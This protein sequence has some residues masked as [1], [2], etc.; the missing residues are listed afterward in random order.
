M[1]AS[2]GVSTVSL[3]GCINPPFHEIDG[4]KQRGKKLLALIT[5]MLI[6]Q[7]RLQ[8]VSLGS[9]E[10][11]PRHQGLHVIFEVVALHALI[12]IHRRKKRHRDAHEEDRCCEE[13]RVSD[14]DGGE[15]GREAAPGKRHY[16][17][18]GGTPMGVH[19]PDEAG[20]HEQLEVPAPGLGQGA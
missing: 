8:S 1:I 6:A 19:V 2:N 13:S 3:L 9:E 15:D 4:G 5:D 17:V 18:A 10:G 14:E 11:Q 7:H 12:C 20:P 16:S